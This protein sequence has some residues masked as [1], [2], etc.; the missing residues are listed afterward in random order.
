M[1]IFRKNFFPFAALL[2]IIGFLVYLG[3]Y[4][5]LNPHKYVEAGFSNN[6]SGY[7]W[8]DNIGWISFNCTDTNSCGTADYGVN[9]DQATG[10]LSGYAWS[11]NV[12]WVTFNQSDLA[13]CPASPCKAQLSNGNLSGWAKVIAADATSSIP[14]QATTTVFSVAGT[15]TYVVPVGVSTITVKSWGAGGGGG[16][17]SG[18]SNGGNGGGGGYTQA[19][20]SVS[21]GESLTVI[22]GGGGGIPGSTAGG[23]GGGSSAV[24]RVSNFLI[25]TGGG[26]G[27]GGTCGCENGGAGGAGGGTTGAGGVSASGNAGAGGTQFAGGVGGTGHSGQT[28]G[29]AGLLNAGGGGGNGSGSGTGGGGV[30]GTLNGGAGGNGSFDAGGGGGGGGYYG[31]GGGEDG[32]LG[33]G[34]GGGGSGFVTGVNTSLIV[35]SGKTPANNADPDYGG[36]AGVGGNGGGPVTAGNTGRVVIIVNASS[37]GSGGAAGGWN[38]WISL[39]GS[40]ESSS[41]GVSLAGN[42]LQGYAWDASDVTGQAI[43]IGWI[44]FNPISSGGGGLPPAGTP[45]GGVF[46]SSS[47]SPSV[48][49]SAQDSFVP[50]GGSTLLSW[51]S[52]NVTSCLASLGTSG[53]PGSK[54]LSG[55]QG[56]GPINVQTQYQLDCSGVFGSTTASVTVGIIPP[57]FSLNKSNDLTISFTGGNL[58]SNQTT[59]TVIPQNSFA[60]T[61]ALSAGPATI[62]GVPVSYNFSNGS[63]TSSQYGT[64]ATFQ[65]IASQA[66]P[67]GT[68]VVTVTGTSGAI[69]HQ[70][71]INLNSSGANPIFQEF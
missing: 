18:G 53:W 19:D 5:D 42:A 46:L 36:T 39:K 20:I 23:G 2:L 24:K 22:V 69:S 70:I 11:D 48:T 57:D 43:G 29:A 50:Q 28:D 66:I 1:A 27:G 37:P 49:L 25:Q 17:N 55:S 52:Q 45:V 44:N 41:Y 10:L 47:T 12:G 26:G 71:N 14:V 31:G 4:S 62:G 40:N 9:V 21:A 35:G 33:A 65:I 58:T 61:V 7:A 59:I 51:T 54:A 34:G 13:G 60:G 63:L 3:A 30:A 32:F 6:L 15:Q 38:G 68:Y 67:K 8:S 16:K 56:V 64:G